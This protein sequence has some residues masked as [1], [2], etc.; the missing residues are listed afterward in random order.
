MEVRSRRVFP[1]NTKAFALSTR[2]E[3]SLSAETCNALSSTILSDGVGGV[4]E[5]PAPSGGAISRADAATVKGTPAFRNASPFAG[6][7]RNEGLGRSERA[8][9]ASTSGERSRRRRRVSSGSPRRVTFRQRARS[10]RTHSAGRPRPRH[11]SE[12]ASFTRSRDTRASSRLPSASAAG[13]SGFALARANLAYAGRN[14]VRDG[15]TTRRSGGSRRISRCAQ[16]G[17]CGLPL[18]EE[19][20]S[21]AVRAR[22]SLFR[23]R[24]RQATSGL[25]YPR[26]SALQKEEATRAN[27]DLDARTVG[28]KLAFFPQRSSKGRSCFRIAPWNQGARPEQSQGDVRTSSGGLRTRQ[29]RCEGRGAGAPFPSRGNATGILRRAP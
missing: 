25:E 11:A 8:Q 1:R 3:S 4:G 23:C 6:R 28:W 14:R 10:R 16:D 7:C 19:H 24:S 18:R 26:V 12:D 9:E 13:T 2:A 21:S 5:R 27:R 20:E 29:K 15:I 17:G 22:T